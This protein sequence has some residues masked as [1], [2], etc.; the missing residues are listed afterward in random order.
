M[1][2]LATFPM[3]LIFTLLPLM[4]FHHISIKPLQYVLKWPLF[5]RLCSWGATSPPCSSHLNS[6]LLLTVWSPVPY[7]ECNGVLHLI[8]YIIRERL[9]NR[10]K[11]WR[12]VHYAKSPTSQQKKNGQ[13]MQQ[14]TE[15]DIQMA[16]NHMEICTTSL[17]IKIIAK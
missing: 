2:S 6:A 15:K 10:F 8:L 1:L 13:G 14:F 4:Y 9:L 7:T 17:V 12:L 5:W 16:L 3:C 11:L